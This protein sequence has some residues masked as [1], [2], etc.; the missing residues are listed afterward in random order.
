MTFCSLPYYNFCLLC[1]TFE[2]ELFTMKKISITLLVMT[3]A[4]F[5]HAQAVA[6]STEETLQMKETGY[7]F[8]KIPQGKP[9]Y[10]V[11]ELQNISNQS[12]TILN[13]QTSCGCTTPEW[14]KEP[15]PA[16]G[17]TTVKVGFNAASEGSFEK[18]ITILYNQNQTKQ[19]KISGTVWK[20]PD[21]PAP[22]NASLQLLKQKNQ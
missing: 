6:P 20:A 22:L 9:V 11:F 12:I 1:I 13:V 8:G 10:H 14:S 5:S 2:F 19:V 18:Y 15:I 17:K 16:G 21:G 3:F 4:V 7:D